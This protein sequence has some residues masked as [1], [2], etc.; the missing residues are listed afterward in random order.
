VPVVHPIVQAKRYNTRG[1]LQFSSIK[2]CTETKTIGNSKSNCVFV[3]S[4][5]NYF[6]CYPCRFS[7]RQQSLVLRHDVC[8]LRYDRKT[9]YDCC[10]S[11][12]SDTVYYNSERFH[13][14]NICES[15][16]PLLPLQ[17][18]ESKLLTT[19]FWHREGMSWT[20]LNHRSRLFASSRSPMHSPGE[21]LVHFSSVGSSA[22]LVTS[23]DPDL[24]KSLF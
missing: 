2:C 16:P 7:T 15:N 1:S 18:N 5:A 23:Y 11:V 17:S 24:Q 13:T 12:Q 9:F 20:T 19:P 22:S 4:C 14:W 6:L 3:N 21:F 10:V 8:L